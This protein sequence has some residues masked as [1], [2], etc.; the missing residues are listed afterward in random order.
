MKESYA[1]LRAELWALM[2]NWLSAKECRLPNDDELKAA[3]VSPK[4][5]FQSNGKMLLESKESMRKRG[6]PSP[7]KADALA[8]TFASNAITARHGSAYRTWSKPVRR[9]LRL[10]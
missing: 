3:L 9:G 6:L 1:N 7:D 5:S 2:K 10:V 4:Y 8:L